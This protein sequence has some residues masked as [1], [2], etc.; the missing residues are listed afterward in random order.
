MAKNLIFCFDGTENDPNDAKP[1]R[2]W[3]GL[4]GNKDNGSSNIFKLHLYF[5]GDLENKAYS[6]EQ[7]SFYYAGIGTYGSWL[8]QKVNAALAPEK[9]D[10]RHI[11][12][13]AGAD[14]NRHYQRGDR[15]Y[16][17]G[18]S[19]GAA[20]ARRF[21]AILHHYTEQIS[22]DDPVVKFLGVFDTVASIGTPDL[23]DD[24]KPRTHVVFENMTLSAHVKEALQLLSIDESRKAFRPTLMNRDERVSEVWFPGAHS[25]VGGGFA[26]RGLSDVALK[27]MVDE[28]HHQNS[29]L[30]ILS[31]QE[32]NLDKIVVAHGKY[33]YRV[34]D[35]EIRPNHMGKLHI[36]K[37]F[38][39]FSV[40]T[41]EPREVR[42]NIA[43]KKSEHIPLVHYRM[44]DR[45]KQDGDY[46]PAA[47]HHVK[48][49]LLAEDGST[50]EYPGLGDHL[51][52]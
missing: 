7:H 52:P 16:L 29:E 26:H 46:R 42:V 9:M 33:R 10:V 5:G 21:A 15:I 45:A 13:R 50:T 38:W 17:F 28:V 12:N 35:I 23:D 3:L 27:Y 20:L 44:V 36:K 47:M 25:D 34:H 43:D 39:P 11:L 4:V 32:V 1:E 30:M 48:H 2:K 22:Q 18:F 19:R 41:L 24:H 40:I 14:L 6:E 37:R 31:P 51:L 8:R 49:L